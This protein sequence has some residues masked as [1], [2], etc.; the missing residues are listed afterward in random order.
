MAPGPVA[1]HRRTLHRLADAIRW[2]T[3]FDWIVDHGYF[4]ESFVLPPCFRVATRPRIRKPFAKVTGGGRQYRFTAR[5][6]VDVHFPKS[7]LTDRHFAI[8]H[9]EIHY[10]IA[11]HVSRNWKTI[12][13]A[14]F[15]QDSKV[16][17]Y[18]FPIPLD[19]RQPGRV[20]RL[21]SARLIYEF[22]GMAED[23]LATIAYEYTHLVRADIRNFYASIYTHS[24]AWALHGKRWIRRPQN[25]HN[26][27][28][29]GNRLDRLFSYAN[30]QRT[31]GIPIGPVVSDV[32]AEVVAAAVD[33]ELSKLVAE[34]PIP[35]TMAR[36]KDDYRVLVK[37]ESD[38]KKVV[39]LL[40]AAL[41]EY[42]LE[43][44]G[45]KTSI[46]T[47]PEGLFRP[48][49]SM[50]HAV[51]PRSRRH[52]R[53]KQFRE[54]YL[55]VLRIDQLH[56]GT[57]VIDR[58][59]AD[60]VSRSGQLKVGIAASTL[61]KTISMLLMLGARR[62]KAFPK[63]IVII[64]SVF[65]SPL[66]RLHTADIVSWLKSY[67]VELSRDEER[68]KYLISWILYFFVSNGLRG[69]LSLKG[70]FRDPI[71]RSIHGNRPL[72]FRDAKAFKL[73]EGARSV[74]RRRSMLKHL[75]IFNPPP[76]T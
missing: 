15:P 30:D 18:S 64:E 69:R 61:Q 28:H 45:E 4:P 44:S 5:E 23:D 3:V 53:W 1:R 9:P 50:Y 13:R 75:D 25:R 14:L 47:L 17:C 7:D 57:G 22:L 74:G 54:L 34:V 63:I 66:G 37:S 56:P 49:V 31:N 73:F 29:L 71:T 59:L 16:T 27:R 58:F 62:I 19:G 10:D 70:R 26:F 46:S 24:I 55:A 40:Q 41:R 32:I 68:H 21:R 38:G 51:H 42:G 65:V 11:Y 20:G 6:C 2:P 8:M 60:I 76:S 36:F 52:F 12:L 67:L 35:C 72:I 48:W 33:R 39:K 43:L